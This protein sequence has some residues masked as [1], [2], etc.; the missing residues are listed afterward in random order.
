MFE[1]VRTASLAAIMC[2]V[3][4][5]GATTEAQESVGSVRGDVSSVAPNGEHYLIPGAKVVLVPEAA[6]TAP[7]ETGADPNGRFTFER[8]LP[9]RYRIWATSGGMRADEQWISVAP[10]AAVEVN[11]ELTLDVL[12]QSIS[13]SAEREGIDPSQTSPSGTLQ[14]SA[15]QDAPSVNERFESL[16]PLLPGVVRGPDG[17]IN[18]KGAR[19]TQS[20]L[21]VNSA[22]VTDPVTGG[23]GINLPIDV[24]S[25]VQVLSNPYAPEYGKF[26]G[27]ITTVDTRG[28]DFDKFHLKFQNFF[29]RLR[30]RSG[31]IVGLE[32]VT[33][34]LTVTGPLLHNRIALTQSLEYRFVR[35]RVPSLPDLRNDTGL[36]SFDS[37]TQVDFRLSDRHTAA[38]DLSFYPQKLH[39]LNLNTFL[40]QPAAPDFRQRG[41]LLAFQDSYATE[42]GGL[43]ESL[44]SYKVFDADVRAN[45]LGLFRVGIE[46]TEGGFFNKQSR[47]TFRV[48]FQE[49]YHFPSTEKWGHH[50]PKLGFNFVRNAYDGRQRFD[51]VEILRFSRRPAEQI[52]FSPP[53]SVRVRQNEYTFFAHD[54]WNISPR[55]TLDLGLRFDRDSVADDNHLAPRLGF[56]FLPTKDSRTVLRGGIGLFYD[57]VNL[58]I[59]TFSQLPERTITRFS[60]EGVL[61]DTRLY[62]HRWEGGIRNPRSTAWN[63]Q[64]DREVFPNLLLR[65]GFQQ[66]DTVHDFLLEPRTTPEGSFLIVSNSGRNRYREFEVTTRY[67]LGERSQLTASY[68]RSAATGD[69]NDF[70]Q[71]FGTTAQPVIRPN[72]RSRLAFDAPNRF[73][74][75]ADLTLPKKV[76]LSPVLDLHTGFPYSVV[77]EERDF[78]GRRNQAGRFPG[79]SSFDLQVL[80]EVKIPFGG[81]KYRARVGFKVFNLFNSFNPRDIQNNLASPRFGTFFNSVDRTFRGKFIIDF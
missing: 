5:L 22:N 78:V 17:F 71:F 38:L 30:K 10:G 16:L 80:K 9:G 12:R 73:L 36:E 61:L 13:V 24:I 3:V 69:L 2:L 62:R 8:V 56:A 37:F 18:L 68:V 20:G 67:R 81:R 21:L 75:W 63:I 35:T 51:P 7:I 42:S 41:Y 4:W 72:E 44:V 66:R 59:P 74:F 23:S 34:R 31:S 52:D 14:T 55:L 1:S 65:T 50:L 25:T 43:L 11:L 33:P 58:N 45:S 49:T 54:R 15:L 46:T 57:R 76:T 40:P 70:N 64:L 32:S 77:N 53:A 29:P 6:G 47:D 39:Y 28:S 79:F 27:A 26:A 60:P 48:E 19:S